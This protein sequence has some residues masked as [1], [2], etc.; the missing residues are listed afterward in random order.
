MKKLQLTIEEAKAFS[1]DIEKK[2]E[3]LRKLR[4]YKGS[5]A[6]NEGD[7]WHDNFAFEQT[8]I[9]ERGLMKE[10]N[11]L[12]TTYNNASIIDVSKIKNETVGIGNKVVVELEYDKD[13]KET[14]SFYLT[15][16]IGDTTKSIISIN[17]PL[18]K[19]VFE[20]QIGFEGT[21]S[22]NNRIIKFKILKID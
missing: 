22:V 8:E 1:S 11:D 7:S 21:Y 17:A 5:A 9:E 2:E 15:G 6:E 10:I 3:K 4:K 20:H 12:K 13:D 18:G 14:Y 19:A 16:G